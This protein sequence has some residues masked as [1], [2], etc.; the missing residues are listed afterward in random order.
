METIVIGHKNP[1]MDSICSAIAYAHL[2]RVTGMER[3]VAGRAG[4]TNA[5]IDHVLARFGVEPPVYLADVSPRVDDVMERR[6]RFIPSDGSVH[7]A[8][9]IMEEHRLRAL[10]VTDAGGRCLGFLSALRVTQYIFAPR[11]QAAAARRI[12]ASLAQI[13]DILGAES[14]AGEVTRDPEQ[15][16][17][18]VAAM[19]RDTL[20]ERLKRYTVRQVVVFVGDREE[21]H[22]LAIEAGV[23]A[24]V[25]TGGGDA[26]PAVADAARARG[27]ILLRTPHDTATSVLLARGA[28]QVE[29]MVD[30][31]FK[32]F[33]PGTP[34]AAAR[35]EVAASSAFV[36]PVLDDAGCIV[37][38]LTKS[39]F[40]KPIPRQLILVDHNELSQA[41]DGAD[42]MPIIEI[43]D[44]HRLGGLCSTT[45]VLFW[46]NP[47]GST[48]TI[49]ALC[50]RQAGVPIPPN[51]AG[52]LMAGLISDT[53]NLTSP[54]ATPVDAEVLGHLA[55]RAGVEPAMLAEEIFSVGSPLM[56]MEP[57]QLVTADCKEYDER[58][59]RFSV[60]Q[61]EELSFARFPVREESIR[62]ALEE[63]RRSRG[64]A[65]AALL[66]TDV[67]TQNSLLLVSG[68]VAFL[69]RIDYP[70]RSAG[71]WDLPGV[72]SR[73]KQLVPHLLGCIEAMRR[74]G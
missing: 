16:T 6:A 3:V 48:C 65:F 67:N 8:L 15:L 50:Y 40:L 62:E 9:Q 54:T 36:F 23:R 69:R 64:L 38:V 47:V 35:E 27:V 21:I 43:L 18:M 56:T 68:D 60:S 14:V 44:H 55:A 32:A 66:V 33:R 61:I 70:L 12:T 29:G 51:I 34:L 45:P 22:E 37:G 63:H 2:K 49:V 7:D 71:V 11:E 39:D 24:I 74:A 41:A 26:G 17:L 30:P 20:R 4:D 58:G 31:E 10:P 52:L 46:N 53:L 73:K 5:R 59:V 1:D 13:A 28:V 57:H 19:R 25:I 72:V 42:R